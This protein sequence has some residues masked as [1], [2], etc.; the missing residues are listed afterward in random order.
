M[1]RMRRATSG[2][3]QM[4]E[5][6]MSDRLAVYVH[7]EDPISEAGVA[8]QKSGEKVDVSLKNKPSVYC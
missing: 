7:G 6:N 5:R 8:A 2:D 1:A 3:I 4:E